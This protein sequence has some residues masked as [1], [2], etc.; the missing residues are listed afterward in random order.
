MGIFL[1]LFLTIMYFYHR[2][3]VRHINK[4]LKLMLCGIQEMEAQNYKYRLDFNAEKEFA[5]IRDS[6][7]ELAKRLEESEE[8]KRRIEKSKMRM[9]TEISHDLK[10]PITSIYGFSKLLYESKLLSSEERMLFIGDIYK[11]TDYIAQLI[12]ELF[13]IAKLDDKGF[14]FSYNKV[15]MAEWLRQLV[16]EFYPEFENKD[17]NPDIVIDEESV[18]IEIDEKQMKRAVCNLLNNA[19][20]YNPNGVSVQILF[21]RERNKIVLQIADNGIGISN[22][23]KSRIFEPFTRVNE[24][25]AGQGTGLGL[26]I[27]KKII[28]RHRGRIILTSNQEYK[29]IFNIQLPVY[30]EKNI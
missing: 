5:C 30:D 4:P 20:I 11:K 7:N 29:T 14:E 15:D 24:N 2:F 8:D 16:S 28:E 1:L 23:M 13:E 17:M 21:K 18:F 3:R 25:K 19:V 10:T 6:F 12:D 9:L 22:A 27:T 26:A